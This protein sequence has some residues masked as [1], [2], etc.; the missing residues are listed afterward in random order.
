MAWVGAARVTAPGLPCLVHQGPAAN[1]AVHG[2]HGVAELQE[3]RGHVRACGKEERDVWAR[4]RDG[5]C[6]KLGA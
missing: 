6:C 3:V 5:A 2:A 4:Q 1:A